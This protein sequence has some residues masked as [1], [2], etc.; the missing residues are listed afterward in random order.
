MTNAAD[1]AAKSKMVDK[2]RQME[3]KESSALSILQKLDTA[4]VK[5]SLEQDLRQKIWMDLFGVL[6]PYVTSLAF[7]A[8]LTTAQGAGFDAAKT[9]FDA[10]LDTWRMKKKEILGYE[11]FIKREDERLKSLLAVKEREGDSLK[12]LQE[13][14]NS[15]LRNLDAEHANLMRKVEN[16][17]DEGSQGSLLIFSWDTRKDRSGERNSLRQLMESNREQHK[18]TSES[19]AGLSPAKVEA[20]AASLTA[21]IQ[22]NIDEAV[23]L[24][25]KAEEESVSLKENLDTKKKALDNVTQAVA[26]MMAQSGACTPAQALASLQAAQTLECSVGNASLEPGLTA[27]LEAQMCE[28]I[29]WVEFVKEDLDLFEEFMLALNKLAS[30]PLIKMLNGVIKVTTSP[31][32]YSEQLHALGCLDPSAAL[33]ESLPQDTQLALEESP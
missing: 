13:Q 20:E 32:S 6:S 12:S 33:E 26:D 27:R 28:V 7:K 4:K 23:G 5:K 22:G 25:T 19:L 18:R 31:F 10:A 24:R 8:D 2:L 29:D 1:L 15:R 30:Q 14:L 3:G 11:A 9:E 16:A 21:D 17:K